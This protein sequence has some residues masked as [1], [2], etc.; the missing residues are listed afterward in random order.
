MIFPIIRT[1]LIH[2]LLPFVLG[3]GI[4][5]YGRD[6]SQLMIS[7]LIRVPTFINKIIFPNWILYSLPDGLWLYSFL[8][9]LIIIWKFKYSLQ[10][11]I[12]YSLLVGSSLLSEYL[13]KIG[14][15]SGTFDWNDIDSYIIAA[16]VCFFN[17]YN[18]FKS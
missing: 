12:W 18:L 17:T 15:L 11:C 16:I 3:C 10:S 9:W 1:Y 14:F 13:Q 7:T 5:L 2:V 8:M 6:T 4:Y